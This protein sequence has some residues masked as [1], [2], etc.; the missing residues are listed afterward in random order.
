MHAWTGKLLRVNL[1]AGSVAV[2]EIS[3]TQLQDYIGGRGLAIR[4]LMDEIDPKVEPLS[5]ENKLIMASGPLTG[6]PIPTGARYMVVT[7]SPLTGALTCSNSGG[8]FPTELKKAGFDMII[9]EGKAAQPVYLFVRDGQAE[10]RPAGH[11]WGRLVPDADRIL[12]DETVETAKTAIIGPAGEKQVRIASIMNDKHRAAGRAG[13]G[14]VMGA[15]NL[16]AVVVKGSGSVQ[17]ADPAGVKALS[18][19]IRNEVKATADAGKLVLRT[20]G[21]A[22]MPPVT[23][24][25][26]ICPTRNF[27][28][29]VFAGA[30]KISGHVLT[31][32]YLVRPGACWG[33][34]I[35]CGRIT[36]L[37][38]ERW[39]GQG[40]GPE[41]ETL[42][43]LGSSC[44]VD[45]LEAIIKANYL[46]NELGLDTISMGMTLGCAME[47]FEQGLL[48][49]EDVGRTLNFGDAEA[50]VALT[51]QTGQREGFGNQLA[52]GSY[53]LAQRY[54]HPECA[55]TAKKL[56]LPGY[57]PRGAKGMGIL[58]ATSNIG[59]SHMKGDMIYLEFG[60]FDFRLDP[61]TE[62]DKARYCKQ[63]QDIYAVV[64][65]VGVCAFVGMRHLMKHDESLELD[66]MAEAMSAATGMDYDP[67]GLLEAGERIYNLERLFLT[68]AGFTKDDDSLPPRMLKEPMP[69]GPAKGQ[70]VDLATMLEEY[71]E[72]RGWDA[73]GVPRAETLKRLK[74][75]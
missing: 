43:S 5:P 29:G 33:C 17:L 6:T 8:F 70:V 52:E 12:R 67:A 16:K 20:Y 18:K 50:M 22:Y 41:Y 51:E 30:E 68:A 13:V 72:Y 55:I 27:Q 62:Q 11:L 9:I 40:E 14:A 53:R 3:R 24:G 75:A 15:K 46:C 69:D 21:T 60:Y 49:R 4:Y 54:G 47:L 44:G 26:G 19:T 35:A 10:L 64:D 31:D 58:Y 32:K 37:D 36:R 59:A 74:L 71:Y 1:T 34:P 38:H 42:A 66:R 25:A 56:E 65:S 28:T 57:D 2:E 73:A 45:E 7:K 48:P 39:Q 61:L 23:S 63:M